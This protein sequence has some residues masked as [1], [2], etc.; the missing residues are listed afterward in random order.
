MSDPAFVP[1]GGIVTEDNK[2]KESYYRLK[3]LFDQWKSM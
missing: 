2:P 3:K 1:H